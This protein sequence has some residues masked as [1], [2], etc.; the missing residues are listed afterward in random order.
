MKMKCEEGE[1]AVTSPERR[2]SAEKD[3]QDDSSAPHIYLWPIVSFENL[4]SHV[5]P[6]ANHLGE[7]IP[8]TVRQSLAWSLISAEHDVFQHEKLARWQAL[9]PGLKYTERPKSMA[10]RGESSDLFTNRKF[11]GFRSLCIT[12]FSWHSCSIGFACHD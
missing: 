6:A 1:A 3:V 5:T 2:E 7:P 10:L 11:S 8:C 4:W 12:P 9:V